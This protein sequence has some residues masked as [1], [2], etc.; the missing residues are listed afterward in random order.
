MKD[1]YSTTTVGGFMLQR[2]QAFWPHI[3]F[4]S[5]QTAADEERT[6]SLMWQVI[7]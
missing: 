4:N 5:R 6:T 7:Q 3:H 2:E 1:Q